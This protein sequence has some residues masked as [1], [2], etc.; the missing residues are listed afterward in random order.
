MYAEQEFKLSLPQSDGKTLR[1]HL[2]AVER[3]TKKRPQE[4]T[5]QIELPESMVSCWHW[6]LS[7]NNTRSSGFGASPITYTEMWCYFNLHDIEP[8][9]WELNVIKMF[10][11]I[12]LSMNREQEEKNK[13]KNKNNKS[14]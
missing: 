10:D 6:F 9:Q 12:S 14:Q 5:N 3:I 4:L 7:L 1:E 2:E 11:S 8:N 13:S